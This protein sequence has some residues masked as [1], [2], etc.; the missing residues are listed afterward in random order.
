MKQIYKTL[1]IIIIMVIAG[2]FAISCNSGEIDPCKNGHTFP[3]W[4]SRTCEVAGNSVRTCVNCNQTNT[5]TS[6]YAALGHEGVTL[7]VAAT[8][9]EA[10][11]SESG[12]C[13]RPGC[14]QVVAV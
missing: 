7:G 14:G 4:T 9:T 1:G 5:R 6:G 2:F 8:C 12:T 10:G 3:N 11:I 13:T